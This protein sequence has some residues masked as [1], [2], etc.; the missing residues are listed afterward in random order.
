MAGRGS[1]EVR[2]A[3]V[4]AARAWIGTP[5]VHGASLRGAG[6]DCLGLV[7]GV[8]RDLCGFEPESPPAYA[9]DWSRSS[10][11]ERLWA[12]ARRHLRERPAGEGH[13]GDVALLRLR[14]GEPAGHVGVLASDG[15]GRPSLIHAY[16]RLG[17]VESPLGEAWRRRL[18][19]AF[20]FPERMD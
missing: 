6:A 19:A 12:A 18:V 7:R 14:R 8:W 2:S 10:S 17:V 5:Y 9:V 3:A 20:A 13:P 16:S 4:A 15:S 1:A 11:A